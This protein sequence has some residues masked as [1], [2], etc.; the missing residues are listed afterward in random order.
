MCCK[1]PCWVRVYVDGQWFM[2]CINCST[3]TPA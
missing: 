2:K 3:L 1:E